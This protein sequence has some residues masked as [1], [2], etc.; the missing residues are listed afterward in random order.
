MSLFLYILYRI[1][2]AT[3][4]EKKHSC[5]LSQSIYVKYCQK[6]HENFACN[7]YSKTKFARHNRLVLR[8]CRIHER[9]FST[10]GHFGIQNGGEPENHMS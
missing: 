3:R 7:E 8:F 9:L 4:K 2:R 10:Q 5:I 1:Y 6:M